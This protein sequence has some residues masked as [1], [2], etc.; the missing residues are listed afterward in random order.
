[1]YRRLIVLHL[2]VDRDAESIT[3]CCT[4]G[5]TRIL[6]VDEEADLVTASALVACAVGNV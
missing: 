4:N 3:P 6:P 5:W 2:V 1:V